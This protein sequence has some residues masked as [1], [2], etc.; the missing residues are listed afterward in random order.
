MD[1]SGFDY[2]SWVVANVTVERPPAEPGFQL[3]WDSVSWTSPSLG[4]VV[5]THQSLSPAPGPTVLTWYLPFSD[6]APAD[7]R[8]LLL[9][10]TL[11][12]W[13]RIV[14]GDLLLT[15]PDLDGA[16]RRVDVYGA[17]GTR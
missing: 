2:A 8:R 9:A 12:Q 17:G 14:R 5:A 15:N 16:I 11:P 13:E 6:Q 7:A 4:Y 1:A 10:R 3:A